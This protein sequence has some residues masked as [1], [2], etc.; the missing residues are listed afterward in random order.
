MTQLKPRSRRIY[1]ADDD[2]DDLDL[3][4]EIIA[5]IP[6]NSIVC[7]SDGKYL[8]DQLI[9]VKTEELP[10]LIILDINMPLWTGQKT[11]AA[12]REIDRLRDIRIVIIT[13]S[14]YE[15]DKAVWRQ[16]DIPMYTKASSYSDVKELFYYLLAG[17]NHTTA[18]N[19]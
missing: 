16:L 13:T 6:G 8:Y 9:Q 11:V 14:R 7:F 4:Q 19:L 3:Y 15:Q 10:D 18:Q 12:I 17:E 2:P 5:A 1:I